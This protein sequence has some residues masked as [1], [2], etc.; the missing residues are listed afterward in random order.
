M[1][2]DQTTPPSWTVQDIVISFSKFLTEEGVPF[3][4]IGGFS[5]GF[6]DLGRVT[7]DIDFKVSFEA[8]RW[9]ELQKMLKSDPRISN[10]RA[11]YTSEPDIPDLLR[12]EWKGY[13][14][15]LLVANSDYQKEVIRR[16]R[17]FSFFGHSLYVASPEDLI[18]LKLIADRSQDRTDIELLFKNISDLN[19]AYIRQWCKVW[20]VEERLN[21][22]IPQNNKT[23]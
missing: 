4:I 7:K 6:Y 14:I 8:G 9:P 11:H 5:L 17:T 19:Q 13:P 23:P 22:V 21:S 15:D 10:F 12:F 3:C 20:E 2:E 16:K 18:I 1:A